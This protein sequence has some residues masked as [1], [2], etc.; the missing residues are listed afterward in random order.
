MNVECSGLIENVAGGKHC[1]HGHATTYACFG[2]FGIPACTREDLVFDEA[3][4]IVRIS[5]WPESTS[6]RISNGSTK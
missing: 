3:R 2:L 6:P 5:P 4:K 1:R